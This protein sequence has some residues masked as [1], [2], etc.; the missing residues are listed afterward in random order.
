ME[1]LPSKSIQPKARDEFMKPNFVPASNPEDVR[2]DYSTREAKNGYQPKREFEM[3]GKKGDGG[4]R[5]G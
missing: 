3:S 1:S 2:E 5:L 4:W